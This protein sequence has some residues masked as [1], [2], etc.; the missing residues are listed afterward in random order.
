[1]ESIEEGSSENMSAG[2]M[3][4][5]NRGSGIH[6]MEDD[7]TASRRQAASSIMTE[8]FIGNSNRYLIKTA[9]ERP[10]QYLGTTGRDF[11]D[12]VSAGVPR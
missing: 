7:M 5:R 9:G 6:Y 10:S 8:D 11:E 4:L 2:A 12:D 1:M 3:K